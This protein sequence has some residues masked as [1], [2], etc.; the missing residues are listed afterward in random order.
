MKEL[1]FQIFSWNLILRVF[2]CE[3]TFLWHV[4]NATLKNSELCVNGETFFM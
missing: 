1:N 4:I 3:S 2:M